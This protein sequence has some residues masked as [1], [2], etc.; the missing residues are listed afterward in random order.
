MP[1]L[2]SVQ[3]TFNTHDDNKNSS[4]ML[5]VFIKNR[6]N[7]SLSPESHSD[8]ISNCLSY[9]RYA[10]GDLN[11]D[12]PNPYLAYGLNLAPGE[13]FED[14]SSWTFKLVLR[15]STISVDEIVLPVVNVHIL[16][17]DRDRW[18]FDYTVTLTFDNFAQFS[19]SSNFDGVPGIILDQDNRNH[20]GIGIENP[21]RTLP[22]PTPTKPVTDA[23][24]KKVTL[25]FATHN[26]NKN[27]DTR[28]NVHIVNRLS[29]TSA[30]DIA[31]G[32]NILKGQEFPDPSYMPFTWSSEDGSLASN[33]IRLAD[34]VLPMSSSQVMM[35]AG[36]ST[37]RSLSNSAIRISTTSARS[38]RH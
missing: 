36:Y 26:D 27:A 2:K 19:F 21:L 28:L 12:D 9:L 34:M 22:L 6:L 30:Q 17:D 11:D 16:A 14:P 25:E 8:F 15:S 5:H 31:I 23:V 32:L 3:I 35:T 1:L 38:T 13:E 7:S 10:A 4:T 29:A 37:I 18:I 33:A 24:L 20:S